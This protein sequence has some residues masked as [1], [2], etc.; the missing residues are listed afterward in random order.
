M[1][2]KSERDASVGGWV[3]VLLVA[4]DCSK[5]V[6]KCV[7]AIVRMRQICGYACKFFCPRHRRLKAH[8]DVGW[9]TGVDARL[10][11]EERESVLVLVRMEETAY[12]S[13][14]MRWRM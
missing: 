2:N 5:Q 12:K 9:R 14:T 7:E 1:L 6:R 13:K 11:A 10:R 4:S 3:V 8:T